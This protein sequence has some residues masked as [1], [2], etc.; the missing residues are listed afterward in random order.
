MIRT[1]TSVELRRKYRDAMD[2]I[3][4]AEDAIEE[5]RLREEYAE[6]I[7]VVEDGERDFPDWRYSVCFV[8]EDDLA[9][10]YQ[11]NPYNFFPNVEEKMLDF[12]DWDKVAREVLADS[13]MAIEWDDT[14]WYYV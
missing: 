13:P 10:F 8:H 5:A 6:L 12:I 3:E 14:L 1:I 11:A 4:D 2:E 9:E 7:K